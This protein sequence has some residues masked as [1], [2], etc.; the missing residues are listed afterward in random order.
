[1][2]EPPS[3]PRIGD[4]VGLNDTGLEFVVVDVDL[5]TE[6]ASLLPAE[7]IV[8]VPLPRI[9][10]RVGLNDAGLEF[11]VVD[12]DLETETASLLPAEAIVTVPREQVRHVAQGPVL[13]KPRCL[14]RKPRLVV[15]TALK[16]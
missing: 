13:H 12:V 11:V 2:T 7:A 5:E 4:H 15:D 1:M 8:T 14:R 3:F 10:D 6:T 16:P 9:G